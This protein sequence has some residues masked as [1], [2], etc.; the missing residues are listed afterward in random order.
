LL[1]TGISIAYNYRLKDIALAGNACIAASMAIPFAF[2]AIVAAGNAGEGALAIASVALISG[3]GREIAKTV[4]DMRGDMKARGSKTI[5]FVVGRKNALLLSG[6]LFILSVPLS[7]VPFVS[8]LD[9]N[10]AAIA[11]V[12]LADG[13]FI[14][15]AWVASGKPS[16]REIAR[17]RR[18]SLAAAG[19]GL[20]G[21]L[22][23]ALI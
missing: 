23:A 6:L 11:L 16:D 22:A 17:I 13:G 3:L 5:P 20:L 4:E 14:Y 1:F 10:A 7:I 15:F 2:G 12:A 8:G 21:Y 19:V 9:A 18:W